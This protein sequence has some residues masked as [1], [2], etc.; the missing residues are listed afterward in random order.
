VFSIPVDGDVRI[1]VFDI[2]G[3]KIAAIVN[4]AMKSGIYRTDFFG[5]GLPAG[6]YMYR[7]KSGRYEAVRK[8][9]LVR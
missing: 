5:S 4:G 7:M 6:V 3:K 8:M 1:D 9:L 2:V